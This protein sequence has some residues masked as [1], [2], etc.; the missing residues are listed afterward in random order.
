M[1][2]DADGQ[3]SGPGRQVFDPGLQPERTALA[4]RRTGLALTV[5]SL[6]AVRILPQVLGAWAVVPAGLGV[7]LSVAVLVVAHRR[8]VRVHRLLVGSDSDRVPLS[9][10]VLPLLVTVVAGGGAVAA[11]VVVL[12]LAFARWTPT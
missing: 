12:T 7:T 6:V 3:P 9:S 4:W 10:G 1:S 2:I 11:L 5:A 8:H